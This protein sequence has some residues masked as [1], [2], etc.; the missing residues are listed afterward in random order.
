MVRLSPHHRIEIFVLR[1]CRQEIAKV[2]WC[3]VCVCVCVCVCVRESVRESVRAEMIYMWWE[4][5]TTFRMS[6]SP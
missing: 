6:P 1:T 5:C 4:L 3:G 2:L